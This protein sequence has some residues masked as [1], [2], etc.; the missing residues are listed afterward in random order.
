MFEIT[1]KLP[2]VKS[3]LVVFTNSVSVPAPPTTEA[4]AES[5]TKVSPCVPAYK[6]SEP[7]LP[8]I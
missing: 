8:S 7:D 2:E 5:N 3:A 4:S 1:G 6:M